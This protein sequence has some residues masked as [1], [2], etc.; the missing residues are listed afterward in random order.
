FQFLVQGSP[1]LGVQRNPKVITPAAQGRSGAKVKEVPK[2][3]RLQWR[4]GGA[5]VPV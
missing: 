5:P 2:T 1:P 4:E 3:H